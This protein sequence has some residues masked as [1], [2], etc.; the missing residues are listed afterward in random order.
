MNAPV[1][2]LEHL[3]KRYGS[4][5]ALSDLTLHI[6]KGCVYGLLGP[7]G[8]GKTTTFKC[9]LGLA[10]PTSGTATFEGAP[11]V[12]AAFER[13]AYLPER[14]ALYGW[15]TGAQHLELSRRYFRSFDVARA[16]EL[17]AMFSLDP[18]KRA[19]SLSKGQQTALAL[20]LAFAT[21]PDILILDEPASGLDPVHQR[22]VLDL[23]IEAAA[24]GAT[25][26]FSSHQ[27][28]QVER[29]A[30]HIAILKQGR[31]ILS[32]EVDEL[33]S[34][35]KVVEAIFDYDVPELNG[36]ASDARVRRIE[37]MGHM[38][39]TFVRTDSAGVI[40]DLEAMQPKALQTH[41]LNLEDIFLNAVGERK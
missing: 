19:G 39:R 8:A 25:V 13:I 24:G 32:G 33:K 26:L 29:A 15:M 34:D 7:N 27:I 36:L 6:E 14:S 17:L 31:L 10:R 41:D 11:L 16:S 20:V 35:E 28:T 38:L 12:P 9:M 21:R 3:T 5:E 22:S 23:I 40:R 2:A 18:R 1:I 30:D 4:F 37:R